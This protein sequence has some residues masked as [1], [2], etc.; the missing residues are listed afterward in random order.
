MENLKNI[1]DNNY[2][3]NKALLS[4]IIEKTITS[5]S[6][7]G[8]YLVIGFEDCTYISLFDDGQ[9]CCE[10]RYITCDDDLNFLVGKQIIDV[11]KKN[12]NK[13]YEDDVHEIMFVE[14][15]FVEILTKDGSI[16]LCTHNEHNGYY[17]GFS[18]AIDK[19][20]YGLLKEGESE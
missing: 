20:K 18:I 10:K 17:G 1:L 5:C 9:S 19:G 13:T 7:N 4:D 8:N 15:M 11:V 14:I 12:F 2:S 3:S 6:L 16:T